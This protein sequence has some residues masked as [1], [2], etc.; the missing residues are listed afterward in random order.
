MLISTDAFKKKEKTDYSLHIFAFEKLFVAIAIDNQTKEIAAFDKTG[1]ISDLDLIQ[2]KFTEVQVIVINDQFTLVPEGIFI[3]DK[4]Q[5]YLNFSTEI[6]D[7]SE[8]RVTKNKLYSL[9]TIWHLDKTL[10]N[11]ITIHWPESNFSHFIGYQLGKLNE[12]SS[13]NILF[14]DALKEC[15]SIFLF[16]NQELQ[17]ANH[18]NT[19][20]NEDALYY[21]LLTLE[22]SNVKAENLSVILTGTDSFK[23][24]IT[25][26]FKNVESKKT[27][28]TCSLNISEEDKVYYT[29]L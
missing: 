7:S 14:I 27:N 13:N 8:V 1:K 12:S 23:K 26:Y 19:N 4:A 21:L 24:L 16:T 15:I 9:N 3:E 22:Q 10:K 25:H 28:Y 5:S 18:F 2:N 6:V 20:G 29:A 17:I 11:Q